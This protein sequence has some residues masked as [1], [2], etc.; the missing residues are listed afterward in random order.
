MNYMYVATQAD[1]AVQNIGIFSRR[2]HFR[3]KVFALTD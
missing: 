1:T 2:Y 3:I